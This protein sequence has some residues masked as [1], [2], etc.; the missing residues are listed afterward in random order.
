MHFPI[1]FSAPGRN[2]FIFPASGK[3]GAGNVVCWR[4]YK[5][6]EGWNMRRKICI[7]VLGLLLSAL[8]L[9]AGAE[10]ALVLEGGTK[11]LLFAA[12]GSTPM[13]HLF[14]SYLA[15]SPGENPEET[16]ILRPPAE[17]R[18][19]LQ[20]LDVTPALSGIRLTVQG[21]TLLYDGPLAGLADLGL[22]SPEETQLQLRLAIPED[23]SLQ[24]RRDWPKLRWC[25]TAQSPQSPKTGDNIR[26]PAAIFTGALTGL[27][28][29]LPW[30]RRFRRAQKP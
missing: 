25:L 8:P 19:V 26:L 21:E 29:A 1:H 10:N 23:L 3:F 4:Q 28:L 14:G 18:L 24:G 7:L 22:F 9:G 30:G 13:D 11:D 20:C 12:D 16:V 17:M 27:L 15:I 2:F 6:M 5:R